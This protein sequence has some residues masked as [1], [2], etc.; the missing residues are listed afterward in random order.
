MQELAMPFFGTSIKIID[1]FF[2]YIS[3][4]SKQEYGTRQKAVGFSVVHKL[5]LCSVVTLTYS[6]DD[7]MSSPILLTAQNVE[8]KSTPKTYCRNLP[9]QLFPIRKLA[10]NV[11][12][13]NGIKNNKKKNVLS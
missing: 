5:Y 2:D 3:I 8:E 7:D 6:V 10:K 13:L 4:S 9:W 12:K 1:T 11:I